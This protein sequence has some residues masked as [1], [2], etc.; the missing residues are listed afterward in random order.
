[1]A[2]S[3]VAWHPRL[4]IGRNISSTDRGGRLDARAA[5]TTMAECKRILIAEDDPS[6]R[7]CSKELLLRWGFEVAEAIDGLQA[8]KMIDTFRPDMMLLDIK[9]PKADGLAVLSEVRARHLRSRPSLSPVKVA[10]PTPSARSNWA[11]RTTS[12]S[13]SSP[14]NS[15]CCCAG[16]RS[17]WRD[18]HAPMP[19]RSRAKDQSSGSPPLSNR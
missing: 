5:A 10:S 7:A 8:C 12:K 3:S 6:V 9:M 2:C 17:D 14:T 18:W 11:P 15:D 1:M 16:L 4:A 13:R 19:G